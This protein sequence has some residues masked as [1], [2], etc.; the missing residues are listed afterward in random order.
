MADRVELYGTVRG[1]QNRTEV[2]G[3]GMNNQPASSVNILLFR[4]DPADGTQ[5]VQVEM[6]RARI[7]GTVVDG[8]VVRVWGTRK[9]N[10][11]FRAKRIVSEETGV[12]VDTRLPLAFK[13]FGALVLAFIL[14]VF[15]FLAVS[16]FDDGGD[17]TVRDGNNR[18]PSVQP[19]VRPSLS[20][21]DLPTSFP[22]GFPSSVDDFKAQAKESCLADPNFSDAQCEA[23]YG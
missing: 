10:G 5:P 12:T 13:I 8:E 4:L 19:S 22:S 3:G 21:M 7:N 23:V 9:R 15:V 1:V 20:P 6:R 18:V 16:F 11:V 14:G 17:P 2:H